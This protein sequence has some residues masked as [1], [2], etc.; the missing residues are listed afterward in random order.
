MRATGFRFHPPPIE[1]TPEVRWALLRAFGPPDQA[2]PQPLDAETAVRTVAALD[3]GP[4]ISGRVALATLQADLDQDRA[5]S[6]LVDN[7]KAAWI[8]SE[9]LKC[10]KVVAEAAAEIAA[11]VAFLKGTAL[12]L[13]GRVGEGSRW[14][15]D[16]DVLAPADHAS[17]LVKA[18]MRRG[19]HSEAFR[20]EAQHLPPL[21][22]G[23]GE[24]VEV[25]RLLLGVRVPGGRGFA[26]LDGLAA[27]GLLEWVWEGML[28]ECLV[29]GRE[30]LVAH[31]LAHGLAQ[32]GLAPG[33]YPMTRMLADLVDLG[34]AASDGERLAG[35][36]YP[37]IAGEVSREELDATR[38]LCL[39]LSDGD[40]GVFAPACSRPEA[41]LLRHVVAGLT[42]EGYR[43]A[44]RLSGVWSTPSEHTRP[45]AVL[46]EA[47]RALFLTR[48][49]IDAVYGRPRTAWGYLGRRLAR[50]FDVAR[51]VVRYTAG[52]RAL[53]GRG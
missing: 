12:H 38:A 10:A 49:Q 2:F 3:L 31:A 51:R 1:F 5:R 36:V 8:A 34:L 42:D 11:P 45:V 47:C 50:P 6:L 43:T 27:R 26:T 7:V 53:R 32:H 21:R 19:F 14:L 23:R 41:A 13:S 25:H 44:I 9:L 28:G 4:R 33:S 30:L 15:S 22:R 35:A 16:V 46:V 29:P 20:P 37:M 52:A 18:L 24:L 48:A 40:E 17:A 39:A